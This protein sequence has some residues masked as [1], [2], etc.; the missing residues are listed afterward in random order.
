[1]YSH[2]QTGFPYAVSNGANIALSIHSKLYLS[3]DSVRKPHS[4]SP[5]HA[6]TPAHT[7]CRQT[8]TLNTVGSRSTNKCFDSNVQ[9][10]SYHATITLHD[11]GGR[12]RIELIRERPF[13]ICNTRTG[14]DQQIHLNHHE[15]IL[16]AVMNSGEAQLL[17]CELQ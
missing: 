15:W 13:Y 2:S 9:N 16:E 7:F 11:P 5:K 12:P 6:I 14:I 4:L 17:M 10:S 3:K 8:T 1:M